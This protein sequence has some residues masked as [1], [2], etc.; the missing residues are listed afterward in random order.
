MKRSTACCHGVNTVGDVMAPP[1][2]P[3]VG[4]GLKRTKTIISLRYRPDARVEPNRALRE[5]SGH[6]PSG[7]CRCHRDVRSWVVALRSCP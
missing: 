7:P 4:H 5:D 2:G 1:S 6:A 3:C